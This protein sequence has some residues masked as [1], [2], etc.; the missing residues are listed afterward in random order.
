[1]GPSNALS[2]GK[3]WRAWTEGAEGEKTSDAL[4]ATFPI[5]PCTCSL[6]NTQRVCKSQRFPD[7]LNS[8]SNRVILGV[9]EIQGCQ[10]SQGG[11]D[12]QES[13]GFEAP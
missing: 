10:A 6:L 5:Q 9:L 2:S 13:Q 7:F 4:P 1:M 8:P 11:Q 3:G 12:C